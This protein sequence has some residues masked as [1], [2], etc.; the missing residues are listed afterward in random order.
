M[1]QPKNKT[2]DSLLSK[3]KTCQTIFS[4]IH[5]KSEETIEFSVNKSGKHFFSIH[6]YRF[7][8]LGCYDY[9]I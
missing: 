8:V 1:I 7:K 5:R 4:Q 3:T 6:L 9:Q 2:K